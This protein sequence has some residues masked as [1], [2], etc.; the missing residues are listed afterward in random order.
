VAVLW[1]H[2]PRMQET[3]RAKNIAWPRFDGTEMAD[4]IAFLNSAERKAP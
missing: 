3:M 1:H 4:L 2:G